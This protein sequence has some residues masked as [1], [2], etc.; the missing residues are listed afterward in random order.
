M[1]LAADPSPPAPIPAGANLRLI[2]GLIDVAVV[3][4][5]GLV[6]ALSFGQPTPQGGVVR[7][8]LNDHYVGGGSAWTFVM[9][10]FAY[11][12][13]ME[14]T[15]GTSIGK[16]LVSTRV[17]TDDGSRPG[18]GAVI[19]RNLARVVDGLP[20]VLPNLLGFVTLAIRQDNKRL[21]DVLAGTRVVRSDRAAHAP[22]QGEGLD[23]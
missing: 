2:G 23:V 12:I 22:R 1:T 19:V 6:Y 3:T 11:F 15:T 21:G 5:G 4:I 20:Y 9:L 16:A 10:A 13:V 8:N 7:F 18:W 17:V 14:G